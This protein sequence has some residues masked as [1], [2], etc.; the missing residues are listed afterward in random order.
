MSKK[1][2]ELHSEEGTVPTWEDESKRWIVSPEK[3]GEVADLIHS[4]G[5]SIATLNGSFDV[6]HAGHLYMIHRA[7]QLADYLIVAL[8]SDSSIKA[9]KGK[10]RPIIPLKW[11]LQMMAALRFVSW[12]TWFDEPDPRKI[13]SLIKPDIHV[14]GAEWGHDCIERE[15]V[16]QNGGK[17]HIVERIAGL[18]TTEVIEKIQ[19]L[20]R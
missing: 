18:S 16:E 11:R 9:Y 8:N 17:L 13:L 1:M 3:I 2:G 20:P 4:Q 12:V 6:L 15:T 5:K 14:N 19:N 10:N 7:S